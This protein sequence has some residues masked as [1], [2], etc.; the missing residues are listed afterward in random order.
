[1]VQRRSDGIRVGVVGVGYWGSRHV[2]V[3]RSTTGVASVIGVDERFTGLTG[4]PQP[5]D[6]DVVGYADLAGALPAVDAV[7]V[8][9]PPSSHYSL[10]LQAIEAGKHVLIEKPL[11]A[12]LDEARTLV[13]TAEAAGTILMP[14][15]TFLYNAAVHK[16]RDVV[17]DELGDLYYLDC[18]RLNLGLYQPDINVIFD[19]APHDISIA[20]FVLDSRP[21]AVTAWGSRYVHPKHEDVAHLRLDYSDVGVAVNIHVSW[22][23]PH[24]VRRITAVG[25]RKMAVY[26]EMAADER[27]RVYD[28]FAMSPQED[29]G[30]L[31]RVAYHFGDMVSPFV[32]FAEPLAVQDQDFVN[33]VIEGRAPSTNGHQGLAVVETLECAQ[34]S[35]QEHRPVDAA[36][37]TQVLSRSAHRSAPSAHHGSASAAE[38]PFIPPQAERTSG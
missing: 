6:C 5:A 19:L 10:G 22:L 24:K 26:D 3:L 15:L 16:L 35:L 32:D 29:S 17:R 38:Q 34:I 11:A 30:P 1:V 21:T 9:T 14:G 36:E 4:G 12:S 2:R 33:C 31:S 20:N 23:N 27:I 7:I 28:K 13:E 25:S 18:E 8:A 37:V